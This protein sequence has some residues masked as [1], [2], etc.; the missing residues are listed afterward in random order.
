M[1]AADT[2]LFD[3]FALDIGTAELRR[4]NKAVSIEPQV[5]DLIRFFAEN[6]GRLL[7]R[8]DLIEGVW[9]GRIVSDAAISTRINAARNALGDDGKAQRMIKT[10]PR[11]GFRFLADVRAEVRSKSPPLRTPAPTD[12]FP[13][14]P[15]RPS[16]AVMPFENLGGDAQTGALADGL[17]IDIQNALIKV[18]GLFVIA[19]GSANAVAGLPEDA[20]ARRLG[21]QSLFKGQVRRAGTTVRFSAQLIEAPTGHIVW[22]EQYDRE[23]ADTF[24]FLDEITKKV[25]TAANVILVAG[26][27]ARVW[28][29][30][31][32]DL[33]SLEV[34]YRGV[35]NFFKMNQICLATARQDFEKTAKWHPDL[36]LG[37]TWI[38]LT[39]WYDLQRGWSDSPETSKKLAREWA[40]KAITL[41]DADGQACT[42]LSHVCLLDRDFDA[43]LDAGRAAIRIRPNCA[44]A[45]GFYANVLHYCGEQADAERHIRLAIRHAPI[46]PPLFKLI[47]GAVLRATGDLDGAA[48]AADDALRANPEDSAAHVLVA[49]V[50]A[51]QGN[52][53]LARHH[54]DELK[55]REPA[56]S[57]SA[58]LSRQPYRDRSFI[59]ELKRDLDAAGFLV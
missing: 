52:T 47:L 43:A 49:I 29:K 8:D 26:E 4:G 7:S 38:S 19:I 35:S 32:E 46:H 16:I 27:S 59:T 25:L 20:A 54:L 15:E 40:E 50:A 18:S 42:V 53:E 10:I 21:V 34:F 51:R 31:L 36:S 2:I 13:P 39:H 9:G 22:S 28:H 30:T 58:Y 55:K 14:L 33:K 56:F 44:H 41:Q 1:T 17:R 37:P 57:T 5:F 24:A 23:V 6:P 11:R 48:G 45:N 12:V 3:D